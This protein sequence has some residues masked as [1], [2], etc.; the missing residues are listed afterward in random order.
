MKKFIKSISLIAIVVCISLCFMACNNEGKFTSAV[1]INSFQS[2]G[3]K[4]EKLNIVSYNA[5]RLTVLRNKT[6]LSDSEKDEKAKLE[7]METIGL[8]FRE[9]NAKDKFVKENINLFSLN[10]SFVASKDSNPVY[11][12]RL[13]YPSDKDEGSEFLNNAKSQFGNNITTEIEDSLFV[14]LGINETQLKQ[15]YDWTAK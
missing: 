11:V 7:E 13:Y 6:N 4:T 9:N 14:V 8:A 10:D 3:Y 5:N 2:A 15:I 1:A 12:L